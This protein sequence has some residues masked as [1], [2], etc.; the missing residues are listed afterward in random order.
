MTEA[1]DFSN[2]VC[3][4]AIID[5]TGVRWPLWTDLPSYVDAATL[6][7]ANLGGLTALCF[8]S[9]VTV[10]LTLSGLPEITVTLTPP[11]EE[12]QLLLDSSILE[13]PYSSLEVQVG[14]FGMAPNVFTGRI[15]KPEFQ[16]GS[17][18]TIT[19]TGIG[20]GGFD[21][22]VAPRKDP[23]P[24][25]TRLAA[26]KSLLAG[27]DG[28]GRYTVD[29]SEVKPNTDAYNLL[30]GEVLISP[31]GYSEW[32]LIASLARQCRC[33]VLFDDFKQA[34]RLRPYQ[35]LLVAPPVRNFYYRNFPDGLLG[36]AYNAFPILGASS[37]TIST[38]FYTGMTRGIIQ[39]DVQSA[40]GDIVR[41]V[42]SN[43]TAGTARTGNGTFRLGKVDPSATNFAV[44]TGRATLD[45]DGVYTGEGLHQF[46]GSP[47]DVEARQEGVSAFDEMS[48]KGIG[49]ELTIDTLGCPDLFPGDSIAVFGLGVRLDSTRT[50]NAG[51]NYA[52]HELTHRFGGSGFSTQLKTQSNVAPFAA[53]KVILQPQSTGP[54]AEAPPKTAVTPG[55]PTSLTSAQPRKKARTSKLTTIIGEL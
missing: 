12:G 42:I 28:K 47:D 1:Y 32:Y 22:A 48:S 10:K 3:S 27:T 5:A 37:D 21:A 39:K 49:I 6:S 14:Y 52:I 8:V 50:S 43:K 20:E 34:L 31:A 55:A 40:S 23:L 29:D 35:E 4:V 17:D 9:E 46:P 26:I 13:W 38:L 2:P 33:W 36:P 19:L 54:I 53:K 45:E 7:R 30:R 44:D 25:Q 41:N 15:Q 51:T 11:I 24:R 18:M 16:L